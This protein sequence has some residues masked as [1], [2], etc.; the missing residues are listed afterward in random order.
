[1]S[2]EPGHAPVPGQGDQ[3]RP[4]GR[5]GGQGGVRPA[6]GA[7]GGGDRDRLP[8][9][10]LLDLHDRRGRERQL[11]APLTPVFHSLGDLRA[12]AG[13]DLGPTEWLAIGP[14]AVAGFCR[15]TGV[16]VPEGAVVPEYLVLSLSNL[17][18]PELIAVPAAA[19]GVNYGTGEVRFPAP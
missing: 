2:A 11:A 12:A 17:V 5:P 14:E 15:A 8:G 13:A 16:P 18:M 1:G 4:A 6:R 19:M 9:Q 3:R 10:R 7:V